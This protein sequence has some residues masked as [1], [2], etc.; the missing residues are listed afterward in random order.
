MLLVAVPFADAAELKLEQKAGTREVFVL[1]DTQGELVNAVEGTITVPGD[2]SLVLLGSSVIPLWVERPSAASLRFSGI[3]PGGFIGKDG[4]LFSFIPKNSGQLTVTPRDVA[5]LL[6]DGKGTPIE[7]TAESRTVQIPVDG[8]A[9]AVE[10]TNIPDFSEV[11][12]ARDPALYDGKWFVLFN[13]Q[14]AGTGVARYE[15]AE[16]RGDATDNVEQLA[17]RPATSPALLED[18]SRRSTVFVRALDG[19]GN[20]RI[21]SVGPASSQANNPYAALGGA[22]LLVLLLAAVVIF[23]RAKLKP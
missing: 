5:V 18:Q 7:V 4:V 20:A 1:L 17:W 21:E 9:Y 12:I 19:V 13:A 22:A 14:D 2:A 16:R 8:A 11:R 10:D 15:V 6:N 3:V 23:K